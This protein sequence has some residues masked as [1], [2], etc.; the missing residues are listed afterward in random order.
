MYSKRAIRATLNG[1]AAD[2]AGTFIWH[3][4]PFGNKFWRRQEELMVSGRKLTRKARVELERI[5]KKLEK[6]DGC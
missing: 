4:H 5:L 6:E 1:S 2:L 3:D